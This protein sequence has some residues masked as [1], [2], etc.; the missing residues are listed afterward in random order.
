MRAVVIVELSVP[1]AVEVEPFYVPRKQVMRK[2]W[3]TYASIQGCFNKGVLE[4]LV[5]IRYTDGSFYEGLYIGEDALDDQ[6]NVCD[7]VRAKTHY[8][9]YR[10]GDGR[11]FEGSNIDNHFDQF[12]LQSNYRVTFPNG[13]QYFGRFCDEQF[14]GVGMYIYQDGSVYEGQW[15]RGTRFGHG[16]FRASEALGG[17]TYE[18]TELLTHF[19]SR[20]LDFGFMLASNSPLFRRHLRFL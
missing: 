6:G 14:N 19:K 16:H 3:N 10:T 11:V 8:G 20:L 1:Y 5:T 12:N 15:F 18:G 17:W 9:V 2:K 13:E 4:G 7:A